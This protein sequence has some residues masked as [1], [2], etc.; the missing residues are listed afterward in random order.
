MILQ[1]KLP[2][3]VLDLHTTSAPS[4]TS[5]IVADWTNVGLDQL[6]LAIA[7]FNL[8]S[9]D[10]SLK[11]LIFL[12]VLTLSGTFSSFVGHDILKSLRLL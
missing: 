3:P 5:G 2:E 1:L 7:L 6:I 11:L 12:A 10:K 8:S 9:N 4:I